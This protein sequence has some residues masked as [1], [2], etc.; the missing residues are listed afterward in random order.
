MLRWMF[1]PH[2]NLRF[3]D[4]MHRPSR[5]P[6]EISSYDEGRIKSKRVMINI[7]FDEI[8]ISPM[9]IH[10]KC[11]SFE[12][13]SPIKLPHKQNEIMLFLYDEKILLTSE[14]IRLH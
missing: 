9:E 4:D 12:D 8:I 7:L 14:K 10:E 6:P 1:L 11:I 3:Y 5:T 13:I 2:K